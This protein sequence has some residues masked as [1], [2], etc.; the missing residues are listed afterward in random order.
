MK[1]NS[2]AWLE[3]WVWYL[4]CFGFA[5]LL[6]RLYA[7]RLAGTYKSLAAFAAAQLAQNCVLLW[8]Y[9][10]RPSEYGAVYAISSPIVWFTYILIVLELYG[11]ALQRY[12]GIAKFSGKLLKFLL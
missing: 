10:Y 7:G 9:K 3:Q 12:Q 5:L 11:L 2:V 8:F 1:S 4:N 6:L